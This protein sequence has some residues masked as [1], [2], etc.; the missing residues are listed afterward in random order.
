VE[1]GEYRCVIEIKILHDYDTYSKKA[2]WEER[3]TWDENEE[4]VT[5]AGL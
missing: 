2:A 4:G 5:V 1:Y 3:I